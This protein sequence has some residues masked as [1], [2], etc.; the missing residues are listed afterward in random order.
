MKIMIQ[1]SFQAN[2]PAVFVLLLLLLLQHR[3]KRV[4]VVV[5]AVIIRRWSLVLDDAIIYQPKGVE[6][7]WV[8]FWQP[9]HST[10]KKHPEDPKCRDP[11]KAVEDPLEEEPRINSL[12]TAV[13][14]SDFLRDRSPQELGRRCTHVVSRLFR[15]I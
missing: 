13:R 8:R 3:T 10:G 1:P 14:V 2:S 9:F 15:S 12:T 11:E 7:A 5:A 4:K 6:G